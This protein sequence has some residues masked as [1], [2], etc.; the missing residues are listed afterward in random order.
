M[1][2][3]IKETQKLEKV[4]QKKNKYIA[5]ATEDLLDAPRISD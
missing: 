1:Q 5:I 3:N 2:E 4:T